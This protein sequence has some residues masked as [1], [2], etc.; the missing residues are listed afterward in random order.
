MEWPIPY[1]NPVASRHARGHAP[2][3]RDERVWNHPRRVV[4]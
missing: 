1:H 3:Q 4:V 2:A